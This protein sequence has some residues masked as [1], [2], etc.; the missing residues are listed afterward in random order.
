MELRWEASKNSAGDLADQLLYQ[1]E[2]KAIKTLETGTS[3]GTSTTTIEIEELKSGT[4]H[5]FKVS[6]KDMTGNESKGAVTA[7]YLPQ[8][9]PGL[10]AG[11][12]TSLV[13]GWYARRKKKRL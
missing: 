12:M 6:A 9:G 13:M 7:I 8:T 4:W 3:L 1:N 2:G 10:A 11:F 5:S